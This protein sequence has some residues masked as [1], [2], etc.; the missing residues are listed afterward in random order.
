MQEASDAAATSLHVTWNTERPAYNYLIHFTIHFYAIDIGRVISISTASNEI[1]LNNLKPF[2]TYKMRVCAKYTHSV[3]LTLIRHHTT[4]SQCYEN[5]IIFRV[6]QS[7][8]W[9]F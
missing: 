2:T 8:K 6:V 1:Q 9:R 3:V 5:C 4:S 7:S